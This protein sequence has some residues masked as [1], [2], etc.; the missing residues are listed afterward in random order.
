MRELDDLAR[1][2]R[3]RAR[4]GRHDVVVE[5]IGEPLAEP[6]RHGGVAGKEC[7]QPDGD[8][9]PDVRRAQPRRT[10]RSP[11][12][13]QVA[14]VGKLLL[15]GQANRGKRPHAGVHAIHRLPV[16]KLL[17]GLGAALLHHRE[18]G[19]V[20]A[21]ALAGGDGPD[22]TEIRVAGFGDRQ[23]RR[24]QRY[25]SIVPMP[26]CSARRKMARP[27]AMSRMAS[28]RCQSRIRSSLRSRPGR[29]PVMI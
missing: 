12:Q 29:R 14:L 13:Q 9:R 19:R 25:R 18:Q 27:T 7:Q 15:L 10:A 17:P 1:G 6:G 22:E 8:D 16:A 21:D 23:S 24:H 20:D 5:E 4:H 2:R 11:R 3:A 26:C 28:P